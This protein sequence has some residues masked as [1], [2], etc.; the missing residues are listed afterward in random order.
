MEGW[1]VWMGCIGPEIHSD[2]CRTAIFTIILSRTLLHYIWF[3]FFLSMC[4]A[5]VCL[6]EP[7]Y[8]MIQW[9]LIFTFSFWVR[10]VITFSCLQLSQCCFLQTVTL[11][12]FL[13]GG[14]QC[15]L[16]NAC[17]CPVLTEACL[18]SAS[19]LWILMVQ[20]HGF[21]V[22]RFIFLVTLH[23]NLRKSQKSFSLHNGQN[24]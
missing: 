11:P 15:E 8:P 23:S 2:S 20:S 18:S 3:F 24:Y 5:H 17:F 16:W 14:L 13:R 19:L 6:E 10:L 22:G 9:M 21:P 12:L 4:P 7:A 1:V